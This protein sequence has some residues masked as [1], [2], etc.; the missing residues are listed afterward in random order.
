MQGV[1]EEVPQGSEP[2]EEGGV[3]AEAPGQPELALWGPRNRDG[4]SAWFHVGPTG[5]CLFLPLD[6]P[7]AV[8]YGPP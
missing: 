7:L 1:Y 2:G 6:Q 5:Q 4:P 3:V 8:G